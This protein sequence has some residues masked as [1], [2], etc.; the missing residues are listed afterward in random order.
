[1]HEEGEVA[2]KGNLHDEEEDGRHPG[3]EQQQDHQNG[4]L[5]EHVLG[6]GKRL[7]EINLQGVGPA[8]VGDEAGAHVDRH[9]KDERLLLFEELAEGL[10]RRRE[11]RGLREIR[12]GVDLHRPHEERQP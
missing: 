3:D 8:V 9:E 11:K 12:G 6:A 2:G 5:A 7:R 1:M 4:Q 10:R